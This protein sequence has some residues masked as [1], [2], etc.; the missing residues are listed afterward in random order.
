MGEMGFVEWGTIGSSALA[1]IF[2]IIM[3]VFLFKKEDI[4]DQMNYEKQKR[5][6]NLKIIFGVLTAIFTIAALG[7]GFA[8]FKKNKK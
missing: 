1:I 3:M 8:W 2:G 4:M 5:A 6:N 7:F